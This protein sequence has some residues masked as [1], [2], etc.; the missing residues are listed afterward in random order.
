MSQL[1]TTINNYFENRSEVKLD[2]VQEELRHAI[3]DVINGLDSGELRVA[4]KQNNSW[5]VH[6]WIKKAV[7]LSFAING[8][9]PIDGGFTSYFDKVPQKFSGLSEDE[10]NRIGARVVPPALARQG[11]YIAPGVV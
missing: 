5:T 11:S 2:S 10:F 3:T 8:N 9:K 1:E 7:L 4:E 6:Q